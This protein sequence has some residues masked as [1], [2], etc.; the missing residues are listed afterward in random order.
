MLGGNITAQ[1]EMAGNGYLIGAILELYIQIITYIQLLLDWVFL[2]N[3]FIDATRAKKIRKCH[4]LLSVESTTC[5]AGIR[6]LVGYLYH[7]FKD[8]SVA[9]AFLPLVPRSWTT[10]SDSFRLARQHV[11]SLPRAPVWV[12]SLQTLIDNVSK[13]VFLC[14]IRASVILASRNV[15]SI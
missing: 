14:C 6:D 7:L 15:L 9:S 11:T 12:A 8:I 3:Y 5:R 13:S 10:L 1:A 2:S 4:Q